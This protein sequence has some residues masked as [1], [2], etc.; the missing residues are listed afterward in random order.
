MVGLC[1]W[2]GV[3]QFLIA[4]WPAAW[5]AGASGIFMFY[6]QHQFEGVYWEKGED[7]DFT[8]A[9]LRGSSFLDLP[10]VLAF[11]TGNIG[12]HHVHHLNARIPNYELPRAHT[13]VEIFR[14]VPVLTLRQAIGTTRLKLWDEERRELVGWD[15]V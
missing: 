7:W 8:E 11:F 9:A 2:L 1:L 14:D 10:A 15:A 12:F 3:W 13:E 6:V 4:W 5:V